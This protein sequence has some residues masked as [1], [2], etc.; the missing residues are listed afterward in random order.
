MLAARE[1]HAYAQP[2]AAERPRRRPAR[3]PR[4]A[5]R[6]TSRTACVCLVLATVLC[7]FALTYRHSALVR[8]GYQADRLSTQLALLQRQNGEREVTLVSLGALGRVQRL[9]ES[10][11]GMVRPKGSVVVAGG[12]LPVHAAGVIAAAP[13]DG[14]EPPALASLA[15]SGDGGGAL[16]R[17][18]RML[19]RFARNSVEA[20][21]RTI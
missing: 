18:W 14:L 3:R 21:G 10:R 17:L 4:A 16:G 12:A 13:Q 15:P 7:A 1:L 5:A 2:A 9:A 19:V 6:R 11:L 8:L 20:A